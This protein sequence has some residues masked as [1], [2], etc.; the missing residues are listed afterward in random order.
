[1][2]DGDDLF[3]TLPLGSY[4]GVVFCV[5]NVTI[6]TGSA[7]ALHKFP[8]KPGVKVELTGREPVSGTIQAAMFNS[9]TQFAGGTSRR[10]FPDGIQLL[11]EK[12]QE[13]RT[14]KLVVPTFGTIEKAYV[15]LTERASSVQRNG[16]F[17]DLQFI[18]DSTEVIAR[19]A[20]PS[21]QGQLTT[22]AYDADLELAAA[23]VKL[24]M[25]VDD[26][27]SASG[28]ATDLVSAVKAITA[29]LQMLDEDLSRPFQQIDAVVHAIDDLIATAS[30][31]SSPMNWK[32]LDSILTLKDALSTAVLDAQRAVTPVKEY[33]TTVV[34]TIAG[35]AAATGNT[36]EDLVKLNVFVDPFSIDA[37]EAVLVYDLAA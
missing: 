7:A 32:A 11:R 13:Q 22:I 3:A 16:V 29:S 23:R 33:T 27:D 6:S 19:G 10:M 17:V 4:E 24:K 15:K 18:E 30:A 9:L 34:M 20:L 14:G 2:A 25:A 31:L 12:V 8:Y 26:A 5:Q 28:S 21:A 35:V 1:M 36:I 37:G